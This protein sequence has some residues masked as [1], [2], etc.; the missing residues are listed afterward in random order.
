MDGDTQSGRLTWRD[1]LK[2]VSGNPGGRP[3]TAL[4][5]TA[6]RQKLEQ[7][8]SG[9]GKTYAELLCDHLIQA[10]LRG[11]VFAFREIRET[12]GEANFSHMFHGYFEMV[13]EGNGGQSAVHKLY[14]KLVNV[15][16]RTIT[17]VA[18]VAIDQESGGS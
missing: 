12:I 3:R 7:V 17:T 5:R 4:L 1:G 10:A 18:S 14:Q 9:S 6:L 2:G 8:D 15:E 16:Q 11:S 13:P